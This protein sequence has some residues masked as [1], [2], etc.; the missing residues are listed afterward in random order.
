MY[1]RLGEPGIL[2]GKDVFTAAQDDVRVCFRELDP[3]ATFRLGV[4]ASPPGFR[5]DLFFRLLAKIAHAFATAELDG[6]FKPLLT[7]YI[8]GIDTRHPW[9]LIGGSATEPRSEKEYE[10]S[11][12]KI[13]VGFVEYV[14]VEIQLFARAALPKYRIVA[15][16]N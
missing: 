4:P 14:V 15:G 16:T 12:S 2:K 9:G 1:L 3:G 10:I 6:A 11:L 8:R 5:L 7:Q 13:R